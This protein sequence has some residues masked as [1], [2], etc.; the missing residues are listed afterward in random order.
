MQV[1]RQKL[2]IQ[3]VLDFF[4]EPCILA[5]AFF[6]PLS[7]GVA[8]AF[9]G[10][11]VVCWLGKML[12]A[13]RW[14][15]RRTPYDWL[16]ALLIVLSASSILV[17]PDRWLSFYNYYNLMG[18]YILLYYLVVN[19]IHSLDQMKR[20]V[21][22]LLMSAALV[23]LYGFYQYVHGVDVSMAEWVDGGQFPELKTRVFSTLEN[24]NL[25]AGFLMVNMAIAAGVA[26][27]TP[28]AKFKLALIAFIAMLGVCLVLTYSRGVWLSILAVIILYGILY[29]RKVFW[30]LLIV[31]L[32]LVLAQDSLMDRILSIAN[33]TDTSSTLRLA[34]WESTVA[35]ILDHPFLG[36]GWGAYLF[37]Y[38]EYDFF[39]QDAGTK[40][41]HAHN[42][43]LNIAAEIGVPGLM[44][45]L[46]L[47]VGH[48]RK[49]L[50]VVQGSNR[51][52][53]GIMLGTATALLG[54]A[55][56]GFTD[57]IL[58]NIQLSMLFWLLNAC[59]ICVSQNFHDKQNLF[60]ARKI[61]E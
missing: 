50:R 45:F 30:L 46:A 20:L 47:M 23:T 49:A 18:R 35:M 22:A 9:L 36:I 5:V 8:T 11:G 44:V 34:L 28:E 59:I 48:I 3:Y 31:P 24:P 33:P 21:W 14:Q 19:N 32:A 43:Y 53:A 51:W 26:L 52:A 25:L 29:S 55:V 27:H 15:F 17:A 13:R 2:Q 6:L 58:F 12:V 7:L 61:I 56:S 16:I 57:Y 41:F 42:M 39:L 40:I 54:L 1:S 4:I 38:P 10:L 37:V 60:F